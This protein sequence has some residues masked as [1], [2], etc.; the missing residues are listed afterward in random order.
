MAVG[1]HGRKGNGRSWQSTL[2]FCIAL[3]IFL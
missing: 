3:F 1:L 2:T